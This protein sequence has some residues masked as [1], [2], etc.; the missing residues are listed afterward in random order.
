MPLIVT[1]LVQSLILYT[2]KLNEVWKL[3][4]KSLRF[5]L[6]AH[7]PTPLTLLVLDQYWTKDYLWTHS[8]LILSQTSVIRR[9]RKEPRHL[10]SERQSTMSHSEYDISCICVLQ[11]QYITAHTVF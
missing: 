1:L 6:R 3:S 4:T 9:I 11:L 8:N 10:S 5:F 7:Y 2:L